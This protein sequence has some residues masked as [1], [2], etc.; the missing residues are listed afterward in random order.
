MLRTGSP[1]NTLG[2]HHSPAV[3]RHRGRGWGRFRQSVQ[4]NRRE[5]LK[6]DGSGRQPR[7]RGHS[8][9]LVLRLH[10]RIEV[11]HGMR[12]H[13]PVGIVVELVGLDVGGVFEQRAP[14]LRFRGCA[15]AGGIQ[16]LPALE[17]HRKLHAFDLVRP[18]LEVIELDE[19]R[20]RQPFVGMKSWRDEDGELQ[21]AVGDAVRQ[22]GPEDGLLL[23]HG[24]FPFTQMLR[25]KVAS[26]WRPSHPQNVPRSAPG[27]TVRRRR[28]VPHSGYGC[29][30]TAAPP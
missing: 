28:T 2:R 23:R 4:G 3:G 22:G 10:K 14:Q 21:L 20:T 27:D 9:R 17:L 24:Y 18:V 29:P 13:R 30:R 12:K 6:D 1:A 25:S 5:L 8:H 11:Q 7:G 16:G 26:R 15:H 19:R